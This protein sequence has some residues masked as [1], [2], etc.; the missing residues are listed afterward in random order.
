MLNREMVKAGIG[1]GLHRILYPYVGRTRERV[2]V[3]ACPASA[4]ARDAPPR[5]VVFGRWSFG[6]FEDLKHNTLVTPHTP[7][8]QQEK[9]ETVRAV[10]HDSNRMATQHEQTRAVRDLQEH[11]NGRLNS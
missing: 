5:P 4:T 3:Y 9:P 2:S 1:T 7:H 8:T 11:Q 6:R 10:R